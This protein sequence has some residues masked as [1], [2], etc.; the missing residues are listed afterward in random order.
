MPAQSFQQ[1]AI[2]G[3]KELVF[4]RVV[5][6]GICLRVYT[7]IT[8]GAGRGNGKDAIR[9]VVVTRDTDGHPKIIGSDT[10]VHR[11]EGWR[12]NLQSRLDNWRAQFGP[13]CPK[14]GKP[15]VQR[16]SKRGYFWGC[17][18]YPTCKSIQPIE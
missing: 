4:A 9:V 15:T 7:S 13:V 14:C 6:P 11:V 18:D 2:P 8:N 17:S 16:R 10:R 3:T 12:K 5:E 1:I